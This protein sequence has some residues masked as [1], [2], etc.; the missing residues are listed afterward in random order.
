[1]HA[2]GA[3][4]TQ[5]FLVDLKA[6]KKMIK[7]AVA[8]LYDIQCKKVNTLIR[9]QASGVLLL[10]PLRQL[11]GSKISACFASGLTGKRRLMCA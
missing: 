6:D 1:M 8:R 5:V 10:S 7:A 2:H 9:Y 3:A 4:F 11:A